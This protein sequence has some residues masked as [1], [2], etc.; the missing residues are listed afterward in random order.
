MGWE[1]LAGWLNVEQ[2]KVEG[3]KTKCGGYLAEC[4]RR[5]LVL[6][7]CDKTRGTVHDVSREII[8][9]LEKMNMIQQADNI[10][11]LDIGKRIHL[12]YY[13]YTQ[14]HVFFLQEGAY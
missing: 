8:T 2:G 9:A 1:T 14:N 11:Q 13:S 5:N 4:Y 10:R 7:L 12:Y 3:I 6:T